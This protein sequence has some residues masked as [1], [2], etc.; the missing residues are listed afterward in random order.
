MAGGRRYEEHLVSKQSR[1]K[2][3]IGI[4]HRRERG[5]LCGA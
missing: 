3:R 2:L 5:V 4:A 1:G